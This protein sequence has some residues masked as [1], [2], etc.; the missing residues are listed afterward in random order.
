MCSGG[1]VPRCIVELTGY[2]LAL[3]LREACDECPV[4]SNHLQEA[5][6][7][8]RE[9]GRSLGGTELC[10][11]L[12]EL[13]EGAYKEAACG[14]GRIGASIVTEALAGY[15]EEFEAHVTERYCPAGV[16]DIRYVAEA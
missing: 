3:V 10:K 16:C 14:V 11:K 8:L 9:I 13:T 6:K 1:A 15:D 12:K 7:V 5:Q 4:C 2:Y